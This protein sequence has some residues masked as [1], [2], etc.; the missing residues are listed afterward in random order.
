LD[1]GDEKSEVYDGLEC[2]S[3]F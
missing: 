2:K 1:K 3:E